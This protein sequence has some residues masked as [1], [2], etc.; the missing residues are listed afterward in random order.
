MGTMLQSVDD[1]ELERDFQGLEGCNEIL[2]VTR[3][4]V[5]ESVHNAYFAAGADCVE[6]NTFGTNLA[7]LS[8]YDI[9]DRLAELAEAGARIAKRAADAWST[10]RNPGSCWGRW[11]PAPGYRASGR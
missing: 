5:V 7:A 4:D 9:V 11:A 10:P 8:E 3:P 6:S 1:L 2:N